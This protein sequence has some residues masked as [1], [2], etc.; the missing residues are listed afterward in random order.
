MVITQSRRKINP[1]TH[2]YVARLEGLFIVIIFILP[3]TFN[4]IPLITNSFGLAD[5]WCWIRII[6]FEDCSRHLPGVIFRHILWDAPFILMGVV[7][8][9]TYI[10]IIIRVSRKRCCVSKEKVEFNSDDRLQRK[11]YEEAWWPV[12][13]LPLGVVFLN[14]FPFVRSLYDYA[15]PGDP[16]YEIWILNAIFS[17]LQGG[18]VALVYVLDVGTIKRLTVSNVKAAVSR[19]DTIT[20]YPAEILGVTESAAVDEYTH[21]NYYRRYMDTRDS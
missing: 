7:L 13:F 14:F 12:L 2:I 19:R 20:D 21:G 4:W 15:N 10:F 17:P 3:L 5:P 6:N 11:L 18:Y 8:L 9:P 1:L 16:S